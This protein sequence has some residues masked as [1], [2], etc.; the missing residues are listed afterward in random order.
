MR[1]Q[2]R[3]LAIG[4]AFVALIVASGA[5]FLNWEAAPA[6]GLNEMQVRILENWLAQHP[7]YGHISSDAYS[8]THSSGTSIATGDFNN[9]G[10]Q[11][12]AVILRV[13]SGPSHILVFNGPLVNDTQKP[14][15]E[16]DNDNLGFFASSA[17]KPE[18]LYVEI[19][20]LGADAS[21]GFSLVPR[22]ST[23][24]Q[25]WTLSPGGA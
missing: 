5:L 14:A 2:I 16:A 10:H 11:D 17:A 20:V 24:E 22:G 18:R 7:T 15:Y 12:F 8:C 9:D 19:C 4:G 1:G 21:P 25:E 13:S 23:Y 6:A 3:S